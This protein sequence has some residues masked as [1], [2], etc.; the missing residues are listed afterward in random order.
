MDIMKIQKL[1][2]VRNQVRAIGIDDVKIIKAMLEIPRHLFVAQKFSK[3]AYS[4]AELNIFN[5]NSRIIARPE[6]V[7][8]MIAAANLNIF[9]NVL[10]IGCSTGYISAL[11]SYLVHH[12]TAIDVSKRAITKAQNIIK[13][14]DIK[15]ITFTHNTLQN[16]QLNDYTVIIVNGAVYSDNTIAT[17]ILNHIISNSKVRIIAIE[18]T[19]KYSPM[20]LVQ[21]LEYKRQ[22]LDDIYFPE[23]YIK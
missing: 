17:T 3:L 6:M 5:N 20:H 11:M 22:I 23:F 18:G 21:Y 2:M 12:I 16:I 13:K 8:K 19:S 1:N 10:E 15:N 4:D 14:L 9:D 7:A